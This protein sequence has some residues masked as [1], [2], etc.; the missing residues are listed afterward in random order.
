MLF[1]LKKKN[2]NKENSDALHFC[3]FPFIFL[4][5]NNLKRNFPI[6]IFR[7]IFTQPLFDLEFERQNMLTNYP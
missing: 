6:Y 2:E 7:N 4:R 5:E 1:Y 3:K